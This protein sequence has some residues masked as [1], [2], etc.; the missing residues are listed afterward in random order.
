MGLKKKKAEMPTVVSSSDIVFDLSSM[1]FFEQLQYEFFQ[2]FT[3]KHTIKS[4]KSDIKQFFHFVK[5]VTQNLSGFDAIEKLHVIA[6]RNWLDQKEYAPKT[7][8]RK[9]SSV[10][11][12]MDFLVEKNLMK[13]NPT[14]AIKRP[15]QEVIKPTLDLSDE[16]IVKVLE[17][18]PIDSPSGP[19][20]RAVLYILFTTGIRKSELIFLKRKD[21][22]TIGD[23]EVIQVKAKGGKML[24]KALHPR[25][26]EIL[27]DYMNWM[28]SEGRILEEED[29]FFQPTKNPAVKSYTKVDL[30]KPM[31]PSSID[32]ILKLYCQKAGVHGRYSPHS[33]RASYIGSA[34]EAGQEIWKVS[35]DVGHSSVKTTEI[36]NKRRQ[37]LEDSPAYSLGFLD[38][39][40]KAKKKK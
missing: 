13:F 29:W 24:T 12:Y 20:H 22:F 26:V 25:C 40:S 17:A 30:N 37:K 35:R 34:L 9:L 31:R 33:A 23:H 2:N 32:Y 18:V 19:M 21:L 14:S 11:S 1:N 36:Y 6:Y 28:A 4:Y 16:D 38:P 10:S 15:R 3:S 39:A 7:I 8:N 27:E 5:Q